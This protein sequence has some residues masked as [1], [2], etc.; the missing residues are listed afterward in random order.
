MKPCL[1]VMTLTERCTETNRR[2]NENVVVI[3]KSGAVLPPLMAS[4]GLTIHWLKKQ[5]KKK[6]WI[7]CCVYHGELKWR[8]AFKLVFCLQLHS[9]SCVTLPLDGSRHSTI[10]ATSCS[11]SVC[12]QLEIQ[13]LIT[14]VGSG[15]CSLGWSPFGVC[16]C[17]CARVCV[18]AC[19]SVFTSEGSRGC[20]R[21]SVTIA[22]NSDDSELVADPRPQAFQRHRNRPA[23]GGDESDEGI[24]HSFICRGGKGEGERWREG[25]R[26]GERGRE[27]GGF[28]G[29][30]DKDKRWD[31][32]FEKDS[33]SYVR[34]CLKKIINC[35]ITFETIM[36]MAMCWGRWLLL[37]QLIK[38]VLP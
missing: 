18:C 7:C 3:I 11:S 20:T 36:M 2:E 34:M 16:V 4:K 27:M 29:Q 26:E 13:T 38:R 25:E 6:I 30:A 35:H 33:L 19:V 21:L 12:N 17:V 9:R 5:N 32:S 23:A 1:R 24:P 37:L 14:Q 22:I 15:I 8:H 31:A 10:T 28:D